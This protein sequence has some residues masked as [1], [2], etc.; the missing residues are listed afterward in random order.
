MAPPLAALAGIG[1]VTG[2]A[3][4]LRRGRLATLLP[5]SLLATA[6]WQLYIEWSAVGLALPS[7]DWRR[8]L[9]QALVVGCAVAAV[10][11][12]LMLLGRS[13]GWAKRAVATGALT[14][15]LLALLVTPTAWALSSVLVK[16]IPVLPSAD[17]ARLAPGETVSGARQRN[18]AAWYRKLIAFLESNRRGE[19]Y[20]MATS[21][22][23]VAAP[24]II[25]TGEPVM[26][27]GGFHGLDP[28]LTPEK[29][30][31][32]VE[33]HQV[34]FVMQGDLSL[35]DRRMGAGTAGKAIHDW[36]RA[37]G[38]LVNPGLWRLG[39]SADDE[40][41]DLRRDLRQGRRPAYGST[42]S[43]VA[44]SCCRPRPTER[45][46]VDHL[47]SRRRITNFTST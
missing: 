38:T 18:R 40:A 41:A 12:S 13:W 10:A 36:I 35:I 4:Y 28:I 25:E 8:W 17:L 11:L 34:R 7:D 45:G 43:T 16:G 39:V 27:M 31:Q 32:L 42:T 26:A 9:H 2:W 20:L 22:T 5:C 14:L 33:T 3:L 47:I 23:R 24:I 15:G 19:R 1:A 46:A 30:A 37:N 44:R 21:T 6:A 29:L